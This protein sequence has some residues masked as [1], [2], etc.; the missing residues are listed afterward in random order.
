MTHSELTVL[1]IDHLGLVAGLIDELQLVEHINQRLGCHPYEIVSA[2]HAV[3]AM[4][5]NGLGF[6][7][8]PLYL[9][10]HFFV[11]KATQHLL[12]AEISPEHLNDDRLG[13]VLDQLYETGL[14][15][16]FMEIAVRA[17]RQCHLDLS[18]LHLDSSSFSVEGQYKANP[19][20]LPAIR[21]CHGYSR[22]ERPDLKQFLMDLIC[23]GDGG[24]PLYLRVSDG[25]ESD[26]AVFGQ[27]V[28]DFQAQW[29]WD[30]LF[31]ADAALYSETNLEQLNSVQWL[32]RV[33]ASLQEAQQ[34]LHDL[35]NE[36]LRDSELEG[37]QIATHYSQYGGIE[38]RWLVV[39]SKQRR[40]S[41]EQRLEKE[42][43]TEK[44]RADSEV[45]KLQKQ[46]FHCRED[47][48]GAGKEVS[49]RWRYH[50][51]NGVEVIAQPVRKKAGRP[52]QGS[53]PEAWSYQIKAEVVE[54]ET[55]VYQARRRA[56]RFIL[57]TNVMSEEEWSGSDLLREYKEQ[58]SVERGFR[59]LKDPLFFSSSVYLKSPKRVAA[60]GMIMGLCLLVYSL[61]QRQLRKALEKA[62]A[63]VKS[64][65]KKLTQSPT[66]RWIYQC[67]Q[68]I[69]LVEIRGE[70][71]VTNL[72]DERKWILSFLGE[73]TRQYYQL[74]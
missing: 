45:R 1:D 19:D 31:V 8:S 62:K 59:F 7:S 12:G 43:H 26:K 25:N 47:A 24:I 2:G 73:Q 74:A 22:D 32:S 6:V 38:Q 54:N 23:T 71:Q 41:D 14:T 51:L 72:T 57:A 66:M 35:G 68:S 55:K 13:R 60:L 36:H 42:V 63:S 30:S 20:E 52:R 46:R 18:S 34:V 28:K 65:I 5:L 37:Y 27:L 15:T 17:A 16:L 3:K 44:Q 58:Q 50:Q 61:G 53:Q 29:Q 10:E 9:F 39:E 4:L 67:F 64:Q 56:G 70:K 69:H 40:Q 49:Q 11:G 33:P 48:E 21:I